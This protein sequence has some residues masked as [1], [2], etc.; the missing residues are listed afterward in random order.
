MG[1]KTSIAWTDS[2]WN[3]FRGCDKV[4]PGCA[5]CYITSAVPLRISYY[6]HGDP[7]QISS[8]AVWNDP[9]RW[10]KKPWVCDQTGEASTY[11]AA[12][13]VGMGMAAA[14]FHRRRV[15]APSLSDWLHPELPVEALARFLDTIRQCEGLDFIL[16]TK[17][18]E[19]WRNQLEYVAFSV[20][21][22]NESE[23]FDV[24]EDWKLVGWL[25][26]WIDGKPPKNV[27]ILVSAENQEW[28]DKRIPE[29]LKI[30]AVVRGLSCEPL[31][32][33]I[34]F[35][36]VD[37][38]WDKEQP[39]LD[40]IIVGGESGPKARPCSGEWIRSIKDQCQSARVSCFVKQLGSKPV[41]DC[42]MAVESFSANCTQHFPF[43][44]R[45]PKGGDPAEWPEDL[46]VQEF[47]KV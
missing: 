33:P 23:F 3:P 34:E 16:C 1:E 13:R 21:A 14:T 8:E 32:G 40:W 7:I 35:K 20:A 27:W 37:G 46:R 6:K 10:N 19:L 26:A 12:S 25:D 36:A 31:L 45:H 5:N 44:I 29:L 17:R 18:P 43:P 2:T 4:S 28:A 22:D 41:C 30:P 38:F 24:D 15:F 39:R 9:F 47:P 11:D 42:S